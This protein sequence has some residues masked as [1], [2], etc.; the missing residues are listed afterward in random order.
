MGFIPERLLMMM[1]MMML[2]FT[3]ISH[4]HFHIRIPHLVTLHQ[5]IVH[6]YYREGPAPSQAELVLAS[7]HNIVP[8][9]RNLA[10][11]EWLYLREGISIR[12][13]KSLQLNSKASSR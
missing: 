9:A 2:I 4:S 11:Q 12:P 10:S 7:S 8:C 13:L 3:F 5:S 1:T 6:I